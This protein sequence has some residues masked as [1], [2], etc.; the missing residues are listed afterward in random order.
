MMQKRLAIERQVIRQ[1][2]QIMLFGAQSVTLFFKFPGRGIFGRGRDLPNRRL[3]SVRNMVD[4]RDSL[5]A[6]CGAAFQRGASYAPFSSPWVTE[7]HKN[8]D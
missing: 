6:L 2:I 4:L 8:P 5:S 1:R 7:T 3:V